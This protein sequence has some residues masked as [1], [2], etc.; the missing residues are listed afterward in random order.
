MAGNPPEPGMML[1]SGD[2]IPVDGFYSYIGHVNDDDRGCFVSYR[3]RGGMMFLKGMTV[4]DLG[5]CQHEVRWRLN[6]VYK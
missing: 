2:K 5:A 6:A 3:A 1:R 4:P